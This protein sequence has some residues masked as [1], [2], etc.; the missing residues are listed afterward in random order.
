MMNEEVRN[1]MTKNPIVAK[2]NQSLNEIFALMTTQ[3]LQQMPVVS[4]D[5]KLLGMITSYD[6][7]K[8]EKNH[9]SNAL[10]GEVMTTKIVRITPKDKVGTAAE[11]FADKRFKTLPVVNLNNEL[12]GVVTAFDVIKCA[13]REE[14]PRPILYQ[15]EFAYV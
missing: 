8:A 11:L 2:A 4:D 3:N 7:L 6:L 9:L 1:I 14:Y 5:N 12:K 15:E 13:F 10:V